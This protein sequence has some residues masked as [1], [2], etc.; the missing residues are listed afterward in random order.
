MRRRLLTR[1]LAFIRLPRWILVY[2]QLS[3]F[4]GPKCCSPSNSIAEFKLLAHI[5]ANFNEN[6][7]AANPLLWTIRFILRHFHKVHIFHLTRH[8][9]EPHHT[10]KTSTSMVVGMHRFTSRIR[11]VSALWIP[12]GRDGKAEPLCCKTA[13]VQRRGT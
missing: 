11:K 12:I 3:I 1:F 6:A 5:F 7:W 8:K 13:A 4:L 9:V 2:R 10:S